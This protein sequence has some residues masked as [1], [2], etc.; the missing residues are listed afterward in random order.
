MEKKKQVGGGASRTL[1]AL[2]KILAN[3]PSAAEAKKAREKIKSLSGDMLKSRNLLKRPKKGIPI[4]APKTMPIG[5]YRKTMPASD[6]IMEKAPTGLKKLENKRRTLK[7][8]MS[9]Y[10]KS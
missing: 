6:R 4:T 7:D 2:S 10:G 9:E 5:N 3:T 8:L 1:T